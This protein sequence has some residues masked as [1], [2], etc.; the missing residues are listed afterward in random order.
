MEQS[1][2]RTVA[3]MSVPLLEAFMPESAPLVVLGFLGSAVVCTLLGLAAAG[4]A[5]ARRRRLGILAASV[6]AAPAAA[7]LGILLA[8]SA[9]HPSGCCRRGN[10]STSARS[11]AIWPT[12]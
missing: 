7:Y 1:I 9:A 8:F 10:G 12:R 11:I 3:G 4:W 2:R 5:V 6:A